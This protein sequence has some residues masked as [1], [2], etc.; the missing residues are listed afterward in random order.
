MHK[1]EKKALDEAVKEIV[2]KPLA[3]S[4]KKGD[5]AGTRVYKYKHNNQLYLISYEFI[6][7]ELILNLTDHG[8]HENFYSDLK[9]H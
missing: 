7:E 3:N 4:L 2:N 8:T 6:E 5:L 1:E 9:K